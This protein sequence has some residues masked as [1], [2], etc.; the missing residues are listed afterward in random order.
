MIGDGPIAPD[1]NGMNIIL[2]TARQLGG[3][4]GVTIELCILCAA[5]PFEV[6]SIRL[7]DI[8]WQRGSVVGLH[9]RGLEHAVVIR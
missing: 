8:D 3:P 2:T 5:L 9:P 6:L 4:V 1:V 7:E